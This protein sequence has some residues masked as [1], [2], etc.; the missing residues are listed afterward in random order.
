MA[1]W[2]KA[3]GSSHEFAIAFHD[4]SQTPPEVRELRIDRVESRAQIPQAVSN[5]FRC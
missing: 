5:F 3:D 2:P 4:R 1:I